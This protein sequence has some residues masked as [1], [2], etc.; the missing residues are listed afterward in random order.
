MT[1]EELDDLEER[2]R[3]GREM[4]ARLP[5][6]RHR[7]EHPLTEDA[8]EAAEL[9]CALAHFGPVGL[10]LGF[11]ASVVWFLTRRRRTGA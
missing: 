7:A 9:G 4:Q 1:A 6:A 10:L 3:V 11:L 8:H 2:R 5:K